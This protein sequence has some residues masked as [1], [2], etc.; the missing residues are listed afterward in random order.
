MLNPRMMSPVGDL[1]RPGALCAKVYC[2]NAEEYVT[3]PASN[4]GSVC[5]VDILVV[6][7]TLPVYTLYIHPIHLYPST[8]C[9]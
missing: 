9:S 7:Q 3:G 1:C 5:L 4:S 2:F 6:G 8:V